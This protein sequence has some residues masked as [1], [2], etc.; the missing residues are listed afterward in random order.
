VVKEFMQNWGPRITAILLICYEGI[1]DIGLYQ[2]NVDSATF[3]DFVT[4]KLCPNL[5]PFNG[6]NP[7]SVVIL[8][9]KN[10]QG[11]KD[12]NFQHSK[13]GRLR[14]RIYSARLVKE[15]FLERSISH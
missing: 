9:K 2:G 10:L 7:R 11:A 5:L 8:G 14:L 6:T 13:S 1:I 4:E 12:L 15:D 3:E